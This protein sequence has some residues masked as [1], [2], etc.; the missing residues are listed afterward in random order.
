MG[1]VESPQG[2]SASRRPAQPTVILRLEVMKDQTSKSIVLGLW[3]TGAISLAFLAWT[4]AAKFHEVALC[5]CRCALSSA[6]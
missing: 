1:E 2:P 4:T 3:V 5:K 6:A